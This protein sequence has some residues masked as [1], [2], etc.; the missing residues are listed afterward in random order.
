MT[1]DRI[2]L[3]D[4]IGKSADADF[5]REMVG[6]AAQR[7]MELEVESLC[8]AGYG[9]RT[10][11]RQTKRNGYRERT[12]E[13]RAGAID[14]RIPKLRRGSYFPAFLEPRRTAEKAL[15]AVIQEAYVQGISTRNVDDL[16]KAMGMTG[17]S[18]SQVSRLCQDIDERVQAF[19]NRPLEGDWPFVWLDATYVK[20]RQD[21][22][23]VSVAAILAIGV[24]TDGLN[25]PEF[26]GG[27]FG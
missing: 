1:E 4:L 23:I 26:V 21:G 20:V 13:T 10:D 2:A 11:E 8:G 25:R 14:L 3:Q 16:V 7:L 6:F 27:R 9:E 19:L 22:R 12:W 24:T 5:L 18:K 17:I 15:V